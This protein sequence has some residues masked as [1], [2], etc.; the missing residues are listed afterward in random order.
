[1]ATTLDWTNKSP[2]YQAALN[3]YVRHIFK[4]IAEEKLQMDQANSLAV[5]AAAE[6][7]SLMLDPGTYLEATFSGVEDQLVDEETAK[8]FIYVQAERFRWILEDMVSR[9]YN[10]KVEL[11][12]QRR[13]DA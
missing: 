2:E 10:I 11:L 9:D 5:A 1:M 7:T 8:S 6:S 4:Y 12:R 3:S 13:L